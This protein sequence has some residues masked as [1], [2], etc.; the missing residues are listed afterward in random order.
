MRSESLWESAFTPFRRKILYPIAASGAALLLP[1]A[2]YDLLHG[3]AIVGVI[4]LCIVAMLGTDAY[5]LHRREP[6]PFPFAFMMIPAYAGVGIALAT[7]GMQGALWSYPVVFLAFF[8]LPQRT[9]N[10]IGFALAAMG[11]MLLSLTQDAGTVW[12]YVLSMAFCFV[13]INVMLNIVTS[14]QRRLM[15][16]TITDPL[17]GAFNRRHMDSVLAEMVERFRRTRAPASVM[18]IDIDH[19]KQI[20]DRLGHAAGDDA[21]KGL[22][23]LVRARR[24]KLDMLFRQGGEEFALLLPDT[25]VAEARRLAEALRESIAQATILRGETVTVSIGVGEVQAGE[26]AHEWLE[27]VDEALYRAKEEGRNRVI[28]VG[29]APWPVQPVSPTAP[30]TRAPTGSTSGTSLTAPHFVPF[31]RASRAT[32]QSANS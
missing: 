4:L 19:F 29:F 20:N 12:R 5:A 30:S 24:R 6:P 16:Q 27:R 14:L 10:G 8:V 9:A 32:R 28:A 22:V 11:T 17:T 23:A 26:D 1:L 15:Q 31:P 21:L 7:Q 18:L 2:I 3:K 25:R 13:I